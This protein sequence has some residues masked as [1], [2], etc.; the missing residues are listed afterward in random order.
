LFHENDT[1]I[2]EE[3]TLNKQLKI[4]VIMLNWNGKED[5]LACIAALKKQTTKHTLI[6]VDNGSS[7]N[8]TQTL[9]ST[10]PNLLYKESP[11]TVGD[12]VLL[13]NKKNL[14]FAGGVNTGIR[15]AIDNDFEFVALINNDAT[16]DKTWLKELLHPTQ[17]TVQGESLYRNTGIVT[18][19]LLKTDGTIDSTGDLYTSWGLPFPRGRN[20]VDSTQYDTTETVFGASGG[21]SL[22]RTDMLKNI[23]LFDEDFFAYYEDVDL[24]FRAQLAG[25]KIVYAP[26]AVAHHKVGAS[27]DKIP[28]FTTYMTI[29]NLPWLFW[30]NVPYQLMPTLLPR[31]LISY[32]AITLSSTAKGKFIPTL[33][34]LFITSVLFPKK[35]LQRH[36]IQKNRRVD[37]GY[38]R[39]IITYDLPPNAH[40]LKKIRSILKSLRFWR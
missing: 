38:I 25:W 30:K 1:I 33:K 24:S 13:E 34:G 7:D 17:T 15:Y 27:S 9:K 14:G 18:G 5:S 19:K 11:C 39:S 32:I 21:A 4:A 20:D 28:G 22:Y 12:V 8:F 37:V 6:V 10:H 29:K 31:F 3:Y 36:K 35:L 16:P 23:G 40:K 26:K 2:I